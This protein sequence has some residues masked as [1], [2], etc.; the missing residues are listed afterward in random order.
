MRS[1]LYIALAL[2]TPGCYDTG[3]LGEAPYKCS[4][5]QPECPDGYVCQTAPMPMKTANRCVKGG[6]SANP[7]TIPKVGLY[8]GLRKNPQLTVGNC[9]DRLAGI[10]PSETLAEAARNFDSGAQFDGLAACPGGDVDVFA[11][12]LQPNE[13]AKVVIHYQIAYGDLDVALYDADG[14]LLTQDADFTRDD[15]CVASSKPGGPIY[16]VVA[17]APEDQNRYWF[18][19]TRGPS[20]FSCN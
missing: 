12:E 20:Q 8:H 6:A 9:P 19:V 15:S 4:K 10:D 7:L 13:Y 17:A 1:S 11:V 14:T 5:S 16:A 3:D 18:Q 2:A